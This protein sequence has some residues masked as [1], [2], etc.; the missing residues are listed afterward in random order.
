MFAAHRR[1]RILEL[2]Q[3]DKQVLV[4]DLARTFNVSEGTLRIDLRVLED[5]GLLE[6]THGGAIPAK[7][8]PVA[9]DLRDPSRSQLNHKEKRAIGR[10]AAE[11][12]ADGQCIALDAS[13]T[14]LELSRSL[15]DRNY[16]TIVTN[17]LETAMTLNRNPRNNVIL[18]G[19]VLRVGSS[20]VEGILGKDIL[21]GIHADLFFTS[22]EGLSTQEGMTDFS[23]H[24]AE[25][26]KLMAG[27]SRR[28]VALADHTKLGRRAIATSVPF[29]GIHTLVTDKQAEASFLKQASHAMEVKIA[30]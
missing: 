25:L 29:G 23:L 30:D 1:E 10:K 12:V 22:S 24:E 26:K 28:T 4:K 13:S 14:V 16:L 11:L 7:S 6:R 17:G 21:N 20:T 18:I 27:I 2:L 8:P 5:E 19:G 3:R 15:T 9:R